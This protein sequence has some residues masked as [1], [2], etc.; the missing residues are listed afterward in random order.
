MEFSARLERADAPR[1]IRQAEQRVD[2][3]AIRGYTCLRVTKR[4]R[5]E[6]VNVRLTKHELAELRWLASRWECSKST[7]L[8]RAIG[9]LVG[10]LKI[11]D[12]KRERGRA[13]REP[14]GYDG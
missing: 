3:F 13:S 12:D 4:V 8:R 14:Y 1:R 9:H 10:R 5:T 6:Q 7:A 11:E 2:S